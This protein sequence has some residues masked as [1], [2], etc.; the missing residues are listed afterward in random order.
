MLKLFGCDLELFAIE[1]MI[2]TGGC[3]VQHTILPNCI[4]LMSTYALCL[5]IIKKRYPLCSQR[6]ELINF[7]FEFDTNSTEISLPVQQIQVSLNTLWTGYLCNNNHCHEILTDASIFFLLCYPG[8][9]A[10]P[11]HLSETN[12]YEHGA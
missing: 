6:K 9:E 3:N 2:I 11:N 1:I 7:M 4:K 12:I 8:P 10:Q 5:Q